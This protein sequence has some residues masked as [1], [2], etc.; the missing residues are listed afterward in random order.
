MIE[1][2]NLIFV[3]AQII[4]FIAFLFRLLHIIEIKNKKY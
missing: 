4:G 2:N 1:M 3:L